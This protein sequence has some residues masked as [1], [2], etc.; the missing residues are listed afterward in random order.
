MVAR[1]TGS[2]GSIPNNVTLSV[3]KDSRQQAIRIVGT[4]RAPEIDADGGM[5][6]PLNNVFVLPENTTLNAQ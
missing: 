3:Q 4:A 5:W 6:D 1:A 2:P